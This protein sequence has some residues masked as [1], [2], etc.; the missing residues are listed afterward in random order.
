[1]C[2]CG[3]STNRRT[4]P[5]CATSAS[6]A[7]SPTIRSGHWTLRPQAVV[8]RLNAELN[9]VLKLPA[10]REKLAALGIEAMGSTPEEFTARMRAD[11]AGYQQ[12]IKATGIRA[13]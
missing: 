8:T 4:S 3:R 2:R 11:L 12:L 1:M 6:T 5:R 10:V 7:S 9:R 13:E